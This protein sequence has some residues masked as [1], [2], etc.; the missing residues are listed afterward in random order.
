MNRTIELL[1]NKGQ[2][3]IKLDL[4]YQP[5][6]A[7]L[8]IHNPKRHN[9][10]SGK[11]MVELH[12]AVSELEHSII[13]NNLVALVVMGGEQSSFCAGL[14]LGFA[15]EHVHSEDMSLAMNELMHN[16]LERISRLPVITMAVVTGGAIG[17]GSELITAFDFVCMSKTAFI[18]FVQTRMGVS[19]PWGGMRRLVNLV[20]RKKALLWMA[21]GCRLTAQECIEGGL[22]DLI[23][24]KDGECLNA[25][26]LFLKRFLMVEKTNQRVSSNAVRGMKKLALRQMKDGDDWEYEKKIFASTSLSKL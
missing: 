22:A 9:A 25:S 3:K 19:S 18:H 11:M 21:G 20:G 2:G 24:G 5:G 8:T 15:R 14:D 10:L 17:G 26:L 16:T 1:A 12:H 23:V 4:K 6:I 7:A 13:A